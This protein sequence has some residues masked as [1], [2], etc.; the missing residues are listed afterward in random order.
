MRHFFIYA[1]GITCCILLNSCSTKQKL[2]GTWKVETKGDF[3][4]VE[5]NFQ[6]NGTLELKTNPQNIEVNNWEYS[7]KNKAITISHQS[8]PESKQYFVNYLDPFF[9]GLSNKSN[10]II[11]TRQLKIKSLNHQAARRKLKGEWSLFQFEDSTLTVNEQHLTILFLDNGVYRETI[12]EDSRLGRW[13]LS[14]DNTQLTLSNDD[15]TQTLGIAFMQKRKIELKD[16]YGSYLM[17][18]TDRVA[19]SPSNQ[20]IQ[21]RIVGAWDLKKVGDKIIEDSEYTLYLNDDNS[22]KIFQEQHIS[23]TGQWQISEDGAFLIF[24]Y[25]NGQDFYP[26]ENIS[27]NKLTL[28]DDFQIVSFKRNRK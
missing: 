15:Y 5:Y 23:K 26:I 1:I 27:K 19:K 17:Q 14:D 22:L 28:M 7:K 3:H 6:R 21:K 10:G 8:R 18:K 24:D 12:G 2:V 25:S 13:I 20:Q 9:L 4:H 11:L 16:T